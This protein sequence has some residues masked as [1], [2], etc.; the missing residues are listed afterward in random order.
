MERINLSIPIPVKPFLTV[1]YLIDRLRDPGQSHVL[2]R[3]HQTHTPMEHRYMLEVDLSF[4]LVSVWETLVCRLAEMKKSPWVP[5]NRIEVREEHRQVFASLR[6]DFQPV[7]CFP[8]IRVV[9]GLDG[10]GKAS[11]FS[12]GRAKTN[13]PLH[14]CPSHSS[15]AF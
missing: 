15:P 3:T 5:E 8:Q 12:S 11:A 9:A 14:I 4:I 2:P 1:T 13:A 10:L 6:R 7:G